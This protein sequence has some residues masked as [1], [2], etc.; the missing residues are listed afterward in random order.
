[1]IMMVAVAG[2]LLAWLWLFPPDALSDRARAHLMVGALCLLLGSIWLTTTLD[3]AAR[4]ARQRA[5]SE[6]FRHEAERAR[7]IRGLGLQER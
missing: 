2:T 1:M 4:D 6:L 5:R 7:S 3:Q